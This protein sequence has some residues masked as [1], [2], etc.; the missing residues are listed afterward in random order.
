MRLAALVLALTLATGCGANANLQYLDRENG[1]GG[2]DTTAWVGDV[3]VHG[4]QV[5]V[6]D[7]NGGETEGELL[8]ADPQ[9]LTVLDEANDI[10][11]VEAEHIKDVEVVLYDSGAGVT[12]VWTGLGALS[13][14]THGYFAI[15]SIPV[16]IVTGAVAS[17]NARSDSKLEVGPYGLGDLRE[18]ARFPQGLPPGFAA[19]WEAS[20]QHKATWLS[21]DTE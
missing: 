7:R 16:W 20:R 10:V 4:A 12:G 5:Y 1:V 18:F 14:L 19:Q 13:S 21:T 15:L 8:A 11:H 6:D 2:T 3:P 17:F 9:G